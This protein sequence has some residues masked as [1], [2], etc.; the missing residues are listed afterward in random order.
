MPT[1]NPFEPL[2]V[3]SPRFQALWTMLHT[4][5]ITL[6]THKGSNGLPVGIQLV[7]PYRADRSLLVIAR[8][9]QEACK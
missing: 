9:V 7:A 5:S 3:G 2:W 8:W 4:P 1:G 6:P